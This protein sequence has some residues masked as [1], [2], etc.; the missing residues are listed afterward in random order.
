MLANY[1]AGAM[2]DEAAFRV[3]LF[4]L[5]TMHAVMPT[6]WHGPDAA[7]E[8]GER[9]CANALARLQASTPGWVVSGARHVAMDMDAPGRVLLGLLDGSRTHNELVAVM[10]ATLAKAGVE[11]SLENVSDLTHQQL[12]LFVRQGLLL[13]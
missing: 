10:Q 7:E 3:G 8:P 13:A 9:P 11:R 6:V 2:L 5:V 1:P 4:R 12:W